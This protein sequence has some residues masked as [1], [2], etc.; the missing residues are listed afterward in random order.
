MYNLKLEMRKDD[1]EM[2]IAEYITRIDRRE[3]YYMNMLKEALSY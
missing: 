2:I 3:K 1:K